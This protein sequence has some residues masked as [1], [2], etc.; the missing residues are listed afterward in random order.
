M[1]YYTYI[2]QSIKNERLYIGQTANVEKRLSLH[3]S[4]QVLSTKNKGPWKLIYYKEFFNRSECMKLE[5]KL[6][7]W[8]N[9]DRI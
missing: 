1:P 6:K 2:L 8:K 5:L 4:N 7:S 9:R 3:N